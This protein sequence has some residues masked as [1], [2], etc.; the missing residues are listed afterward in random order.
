MKVW[1]RRPHIVVLGAEQ[2]FVNCICVLNTLVI[3][4]Y[5]VY[6]VERNCICVSNKF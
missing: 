5:G 3:E 6:K 2:W 1:Y 4:I